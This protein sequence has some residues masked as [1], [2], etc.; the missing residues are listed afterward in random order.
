[1]NEGASRCTWGAQE[2]SAGAGVYVCP[3][4]VIEP[5]KTKRGAIYEV[6]RNETGKHTKNTRIRHPADP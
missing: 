5:R 1:M 2:L 3:F 6:L 4:F